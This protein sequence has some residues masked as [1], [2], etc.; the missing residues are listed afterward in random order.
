MA[1]PF[2]PS[3][4]SDDYKEYFLIIDSH[5]RVSSVNWPL[6]AEECGGVTVSILIS[7]NSQTLPGH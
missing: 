2:K 4:M 1:P 6:L 7:T 5:E 3:A